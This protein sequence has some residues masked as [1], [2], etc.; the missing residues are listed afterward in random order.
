[1]GCGP[2]RDVAAQGARDVAPISFR[3]MR[4]T[5][6]GTPPKLCLALTELTLTIAAP[7]YAKSDWPFVGADEPS[8]GQQMLLAMAAGCFGNRCFSP[9]RPVALGTAR[10]LK[11]YSIVIFLF[12]LCCSY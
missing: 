12:A 10:D 5:H 3:E 6:V 9:W 8:R 11:T 7:T 2:Q 1:M 4:G